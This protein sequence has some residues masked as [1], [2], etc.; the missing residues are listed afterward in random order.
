M[1][2]NMQAFTNKIDFS[3]T[4]LSQISPSIHKQAS[5]CKYTETHW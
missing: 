1:I 5:G 2:P 4:G 3:Y